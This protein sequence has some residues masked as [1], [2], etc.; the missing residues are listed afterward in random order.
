MVVAIVEPKPAAY[1]P[2]LYFATLPFS[3]SITA[4]GSE[5]AFVTSPAHCASIGRY[6]AFGTFG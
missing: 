1:K 5:P 4:F 2:A 3:A 6:G